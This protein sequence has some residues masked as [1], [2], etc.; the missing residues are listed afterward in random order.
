MKKV[1][2]CNKTASLQQFFLFS[3]TG[4]SDLTQDTI[5]TLTYL[6]ACVKESFRMYPTA[7]QIARLTET[8]MAVSGG[9][10]LPANS[11]VL[12]HTHVACHQ[13]CKKFFQITIFRPVI[14]VKYF[15]SFPQ[16]KKSVTKGSLCFLNSGFMIQFIDSWHI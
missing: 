14:C 13:V 4:D 15:L 5:S 11:L 3:F 7:S 6:K 9:H 8:P 1:R 10:I 16:K 12:C 2:F